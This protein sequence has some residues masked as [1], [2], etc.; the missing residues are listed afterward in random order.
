MTLVFQSTPIKV[1]IKWCFKLND[2]DLYL[3]EVFV[4]QLD[5][6][7]LLSW[8]NVNASRFKRLSVVARRILAVPASSAAS[9]R[10]FSLASHLINNLRS[11][12]N[13]KTVNDAMIVNS[14]RKL[15][16]L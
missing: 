2:L 1:Q 7:N 9:E 4:G 3:Q 6:I 15:S 16:K 10:S 12:L 11:S 8:W 13:P 5:I 14:Y